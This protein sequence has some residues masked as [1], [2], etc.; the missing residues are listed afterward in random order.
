MENKIRIEIVTKIEAAERQLKTAIHLFFEQGDPVSIHS[1]TCAGHNILHD[2]GKKRQI[3]SIR[4][5]S[6]VKDDKKKEFHSL[7]SGVENFL[8]HGSREKEQSLEFR[9]AVTPLYILDTI[10]LKAK[11][12]RQLSQEDALFLVWFHL[13]NPETLALDAIKGEPT[14]GA[15]FKQLCTINPDDFDLLSEIVRNLKKSCSLN[16]RP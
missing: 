10:A 7:I 6:W 12:G 2:I 3:K 16:K 1:L 14:I 13:K 15:A 9:P 4:D 11:L 5:D 8:K